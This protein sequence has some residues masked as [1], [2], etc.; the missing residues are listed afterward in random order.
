ME[1]FKMGGVPLFHVCAISSGIPA[2]LVAM[3]GQNF[4]SFHRNIDFEQNGNEN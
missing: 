4:I 1:M 2:N 3:K